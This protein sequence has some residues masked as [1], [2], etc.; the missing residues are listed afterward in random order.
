M[1]KTGKVMVML[2]VASVL[3]GSPAFAGGT[4]EKSAAKPAASEA[5][6]VV[7]GV[8]MP[9]TRSETL[10]CDQGNYGVFDSHNLFIPNGNEFAAGGRQINV[11]YLWYVN[12]A[13]G[14]I[15]PWLA[16]SYQYSQDYKTLTIRLNKKAKWNDGVPFTAHDVVFT[17]EMRKK[18]TKALGN[19]D[20]DNVITSV[21]AADDNTVVYS[22][23]VPQPR[24]HQ[25]FW[26]KVCYASSRVAIV[27]KHV[28]EKVDA[29]TFKNYPPVNTGPYTL[30]KTYP[31]QKIYVWARD[32]DYWNKDK[33]FPAPKYVIYRT[34]PTGEQQLAEAKTNNMDAFGLDYKV[35][36]EQKAQLPQINYVT[37]QDPNPRAIWFN[38]GKEPFNKPE[39][40]RALS[41]LMNRGKW[42][43]NVWIPPSRPAKFL[44][45]DFRNLDKYVNPESAGKWKTLDYNPAEALKLL[46]SIGYRKEGSV[47]KDPKGVP[48]KINVITP[49]APGG[50][51]Y[52]IAQDWIGDL[53]AVGIETTLAN[54][55]SAAWSNKVNFGDWDVGVSWW[56][57]ITVDPYELYSRY[58]A[59]LAVP[60]GQ[61]AAVKGNDM[62][63]GNKDFEAVVKKLAQVTTDSPE[64][65]ELYWKAYDIWMQDP[66]GVPLIETLYSQAFNTTYWDNMPSNTNMYTVPFN[67]WG[68]F[69]W[70]EFSVKPKQ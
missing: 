15:I 66:P 8:T 70:V 35:Y 53:K 56:S 42:S 6:F 55:E 28:W 14:E 22:F 16:D 39:F 27:P 59:D 52:L 2:L 10:V 4:R 51:E 47:L 20:P 18:D 5:P 26:C 7:N 11:E 29:K 1:K 43:E 60:I 30:L 49:S 46:E 24:Y 37:Y 9:F 54:Y 40:A 61:N 33:F 57:S 50:S 12:Y 44:W 17:F 19:P 3:A 23:T 36:M 69:L 32:D 13:T 58:T 45:A 34:G 68:Q 25:A 38:K 21:T 63:Y 31:E 48:V 65:Q 41:R 67:W 62:R 64:A